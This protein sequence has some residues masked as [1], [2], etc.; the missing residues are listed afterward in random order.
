MFLASAPICGAAM[1]GDQ[2]QP[3]EGSAQGADV[4]IHGQ[5]TQVTARQTTGLAGVRQ[6]Q[7]VR[8]RAPVVV[9]SGAALSA[10]PNASSNTEVPS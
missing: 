3:F 8:N 1:A 5:P 6:L 2:L 10:V 7:A 9:S 4:R